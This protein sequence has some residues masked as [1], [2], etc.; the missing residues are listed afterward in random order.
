M[1]LKEFLKKLPG[2][3]GSMSW[4]LRFMK[5]FWPQLTLIVV[6]DSLLSLIGVATA[7][8]SKQAI[9]AATTGMQSALLMN[10]A[11]F[12]VVAFVNLG[13]ASAM[14]MFSVVVNER[15]AYSVRRS[16]FKRILDAKW[17]ECAKYHSGDLLTRVTSDIN[18]VAGGI[19]SVLPSIVALIVRFI[20]AF[21]TLL[22]YEPRL[23]LFAFLLGPVAVLASRVLGKRMKRIQIKV[24]ESESAYRSYMQETFANLT[25]VKAFAYK[26]AAV[27]DLEALQNNRMKW[28]TRRNR[29]SILTGLVLS[30]SYW[31]SYLVAFGWGTYQMS[32]GLITYGTMTAFMQLIQ[33]V[34]GP[35]MGLAQTV[36][37]IIGIA[38]SSER[39]MTLSNFEEEAYVGTISGAQAIG[40][41][42]SGVDVSYADGDPVLKNLSM[43]IKPGETVALRGA[44]GIGK[45]TLVRV[46]LSLLSPNAGSVEYYNNTGESVAANPGVR[47][48]IAYVPQ[49]NTLFSGTIGD[50]LRMGKG[51]A[52]REEMAHALERA[53]AWEFVSQLPNGI[54][55]AVGERG[56]GLSEGQ[57]QRIAIARALLRGA[58]FL[59]LDEATSALDAVTEA[60]ILEHLGEVKKACTCLLI[61][62]REAAVKL[63]DRQ[64]MLEQ[65]RDG[66]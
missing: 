47:G 36:P 2:T 58:P 34:Q 21:F 5:P 52:S 66:N 13:V 22:V 12:A 42:I 51:T 43:D 50:N 65:E 7:I 55:T 64:I 54:D 8:I 40:V 4:L 14:S 61:T 33:Q 20:A 15:L 62:H 30:G 17:A 37:Q 9:D 3:F 19:T 32:L 31:V 11:I 26:D 49:G 18:A 16:V 29:L 27:E 53:C 28:I 57:A 24:Q 45:T 39:I 63:C 48:L 35:I 38:A 41:R 60:K 10:I 6:V 46:L 25:I 56:L 1:T 23:S 59:I 44:S